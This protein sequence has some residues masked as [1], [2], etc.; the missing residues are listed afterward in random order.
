MKEKINGEA[1]VADI[2]AVYLS[3]RESNFSFVRFLIPAWVFWDKCVLPI[4]ELKRKMPMDNHFRNSHL[5]FDNKIDIL[6][7]FDIA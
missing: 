4:G 2:S 3:W 1:Q 7:K 6:Y 5:N